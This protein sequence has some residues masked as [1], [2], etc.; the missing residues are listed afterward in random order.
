VTGQ[1]AGP[2][3]DTIS[4][5]DADDLMEVRHFVAA[6]AAALGLE[7]GRVDVL[8]LAVSELA[9]NT[10][11]HTSGGG[12]VRVWAQAA[13]IICD[14]VDSGPMRA[15]GRRMPAADSLR[16]RGLAIVER[17]CD[18]VDVYAVAEGTLVRV[19]LNL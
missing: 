15:L 3:N 2:D 12:H 11:Q 17:L 1:P 10:V 14:V 18:A 9:T 4:Y 19:R 5:T 13:Q 8:T 16:G 7:A 6:R